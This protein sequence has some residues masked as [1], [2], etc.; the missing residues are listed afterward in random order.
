MKQKEQ[1]YSTSGEVKSRPH[2]YVVEETTPLPRN[3]NKTFQLSPI[4]S[5]LWVVEW[6]QVNFCTTL[7]Q[8]VELN[9]GQ[10]CL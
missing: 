7:I 10:K 3:L 1:I 9:E 5:F 8:K 6:V 4:K 2:T